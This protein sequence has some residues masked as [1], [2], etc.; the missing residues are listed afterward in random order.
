MWIARAR[1]LLGTVVSIQAHAEALD[2]ASVEQAISQAF[3]VVAHIGRVMSAHDGDSD[4]GRMSRAIQGEVLTLDAHTVHVI[5][6]AQ[7]AWQLSRGAFNPCR[8]A[9]L[10]SRAGLRPGIAGDA[11]GSLSDIAMGSATQVQLAHPIKLDFG[12]IAKGYAVDQAIEVL[13][14]Y[15]VRHALVN[16]GGDLRAIGERHWPID[17]RHANITLM[18]GR[19]TQKTRLHQQ[20]LATSVAGELNPEFVFARSHKKSAW[21][22]VTVQASTCM[23]ADVLTKWAMQASFLCPDLRAALRQNHARMWRTP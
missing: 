22:S 2:G 13:A 11:T 20:A 7:H 6:A 12:G 18:D 9:H 19:L 10:L 21:R 23:T 17:V 8:A 4:L 16:A 3:A 5:R 15:G 14:A 1:P